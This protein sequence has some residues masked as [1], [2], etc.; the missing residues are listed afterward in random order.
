MK[1]KKAPTSVDRIFGKSLV[2]SLRQAMTPLERFVH[3][4]ASFGLLLTACTV[5]AM[6]FY[7][8]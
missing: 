5:I 4:E 7:D 2:K 6:L 3:S 8:V 1:Q